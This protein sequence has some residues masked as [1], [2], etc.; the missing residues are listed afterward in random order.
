MSLTAQLNGLRVAAVL[1]SRE[2]KQVFLGAFGGWVLPLVP[3]RWWYRVLFRSP[4]GMMRVA[5]ERVLAD[6]RDF[7]GF[8]GETIFHADPQVLAFREGKR[9][10]VNR[11]FKHLNLDEAQVQQMIGVDD[12]IG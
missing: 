6:L 5:S 1:R 11:I 10:A 2:Y 12:G 9:A 4:E 3:S 8:N 7:A